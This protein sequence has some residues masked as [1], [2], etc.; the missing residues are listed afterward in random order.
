VAQSIHERD[1][2]AV[3]FWTFCEDLAPGPSPA[4]Y[5]DALSRLHA[6]MRQLDVK[7]PH[8][9][10]RITEAEHLVGDRQESPELAE[11]DRALLADTLRE[12]RT[13]IAHRSRV[14]QLLHGEPHPGNVLDG[15]SGPIFIDFET[16]CRGPVEFDVA[17]VPDEVATC[18]PGLDRA[19]LSDCRRLVLAMV[20]AWR[21]DSRDEFPEGRQ[22]G[23]AIVA[24]LRK[25]P[26]WPTLG[27]LNP[28]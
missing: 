3:T 8:F 1:G 22:H 11:A 2:F 12:A 24:L 4:S 6:D 17:H 27:A 13:L 25:G 26:P 10:E 9:T 5:A 7:V 16:C 18:Y 23:E 21:W 15:G 19:L 28:R 20:A 14:D